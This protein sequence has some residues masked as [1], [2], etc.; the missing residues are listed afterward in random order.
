MEIPQLNQPLLTEE[1]LVVLFYL[2]LLDFL[3]FITVF[4]LFKHFEDLE[5]NIRFSVYGFSLLPMSMEKG[6]EP[7][8]GMS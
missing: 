2:I 6:V 4:I 1:Y 7:P 8:D 3:L 5:S